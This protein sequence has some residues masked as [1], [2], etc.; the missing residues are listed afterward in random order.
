MTADELVSSPP[1]SGTGK[2]VPTWATPPEWMTTF[3]QLMAAGTSVTSCAQRLNKPANMLRKVLD[4]PEF[5]KLVADYTAE[6]GSNS[7]EKLIGGARV[8]CVLRLI[9]LRDNPTTHPRDVIAVCKWFLERKD[10]VSDEQLGDLI[11]KHGDDLSSGL[12]KEIA[13]HLDA[14]PELRRRT[15]PGQPDPVLNGPEP[16]QGGRSVFAGMAA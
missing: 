5:Q 7:P 1:K 6:S 12:D 13:R 10:Y 14:R 16:A 9:A 4:L 3:A 11:Q 15:I 8:D 2:A